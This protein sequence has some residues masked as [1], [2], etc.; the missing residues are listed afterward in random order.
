MES[1]GLPD[2]IHVS[3]VT[4]ELIKNHVKLESRGMREIKGKGSM[5]TF[6]VVQ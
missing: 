6:F 3:S 2:K 1:Y 4:A 5:E